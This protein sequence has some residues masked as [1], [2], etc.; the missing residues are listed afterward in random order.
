VQLAESI[1][2]CLEPMMT[3]KVFANPK[4][5]ADV[6]HLMALQRQQ[7]DKIVTE[8]ATLGIDVI[9]DRIIRYKRRWREALAYVDD[10]ASI[11]DIGSGWINSEL[12]ELI[13]NTRHMNYFALDA[14]PNVIDGIAKKL[15]DAGL[16][17][18]NSV[19]GE[20]SSL[21]FE[22]QFDMV[23]SS[24]CLE[25]SIDIVDALLEIRRVLNSN[26]YLFIS[27][28]LGFDFSDEHTLF[29]GPDEWMS[30]LEN[31]GFDVVSNIIGTVYSTSADLTI[32]ASKNDRLKIDERAARTISNLFTKA[33]RTYLNHDD[34]IFSY[35]GN[36][37]NQLKETILSG[38]GS[39]C[40]IQSDQPI[41]ALVFVRHKWSG[42]V[43]ISDG[44]RQ[45]AFD[46]YS[47]FQHYCG[48]SLEGFSRK[49]NVSIVGAN[50]LAHGTE[51][52]IAGAL[53]SS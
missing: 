21:P 48:V 33:G 41:S 39:N 18:S 49:I 13:V 46:A 44:Q 5:I 43:L 12:F 36:Q 37:S 11:L 22:K 52:V 38:V 29:L 42:C 50:T 35:N 34:H 17:K 9:S 40:I 28:P 23:F 31:M 3:K 6:Q 4:D 7:F 8:N 1:S 19:V 20:A 24:H 25:H 30:L 47:R 53:L 16:S 15:A 32:L 10:G 14:D 2:A 51:C 26:G 27:I 45:I